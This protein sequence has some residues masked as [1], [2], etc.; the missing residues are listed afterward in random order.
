MNEKTE[1]PRPRRPRGTGF[2]TFPLDESARVIKDAGKY[3][4]THTDAALAGYM[5]HDST[6][7]GP[8]RAKLASLRDWGL[9]R[10][11][12]ENRQ[13]PFT[14]LGHQIA[15]AATAEE[16]KRLLREAFFSA[17]AFAAI[18]NESAKGAALTL[19]FIGG[20][21]VT[22]F[23]VSA[24]SKQRFAD[25]FAQSVVA[26]GLGSRGDKGT[27]RLIPAEA[28]Q[29]EGATAPDA[30]RA[31]NGRPTTEATPQ[32]G[33]SLQQTRQEIRTGGRVPALHQEW[34][35]N[36]GRVLFEVELD[37][38]LTASNFGSIAKVMPELEEFVQSLGPAESAETPIAPAAPAE[39]DSP[40]EQDGGEE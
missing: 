38:P 2:P 35:V 30:G 21:A 19:E 7:S 6:R 36:G 23:G 31:S 32:T 27:I 22:Q 1:T 39:T 13:V 12:D 33:T 37:K 15:H 18:Y 29:E 10:R 17:S 25:S 34:Q 16:E 26:A 20:R 5:G 40:P 24:P 3:G 11:P 14:D 9:I 28:A 8:F 4:R